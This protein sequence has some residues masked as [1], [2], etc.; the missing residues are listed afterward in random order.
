MCVRACVCLRLGPGP[1]AAPLWRDH[2]VAVRQPAGNDNS[3]GI[4]QM[5]EEG[6]HGY[7]ANAD[8]LEHQ[9][10]GGNGARSKHIL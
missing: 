8:V 10:P 3:R 4:A 6:Q 7:E 1:G 9:Q 2:R 5:D